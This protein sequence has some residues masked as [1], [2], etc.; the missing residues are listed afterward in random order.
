[1][2]I[3]RLIILSGP[4]CAGKTPLLDALQRVYPHLDFYRPILYSS[5][6]PRPGER[7]GIHFHFRSPEEIQQLPQERYLVGQVR[8]IWQALD[9]HELR[10]ALQNQPLAI[11]EIYPTLAKTLVNRCSDWL[12]LHI[13]RI[14]VAPV[15]HEEI[16]SLIEYMSFPS[17]HQAM[18][19][20]MAHKQVLRAMQQGKILSPDE[21]DDI[22]QRASRAYDELEMAKDYDY[23]LINHD[24]EDSPHWR[25]TPPLGQAGETLA[26]LYKILTN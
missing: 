10:S 15:T 24:T 26:R 7:D 9:L 23:I 13:E 5:R 1:M 2:S 20:V 4:S 25:F 3:H 21:L 8:H 18:A 14:F 22:R 11:A 16:E 17:P 12:S 6:K 19:A